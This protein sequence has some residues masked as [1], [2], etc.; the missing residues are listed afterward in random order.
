MKGRPSNIPASASARLLKLAKER[1][2]DYQLVLLRYANE[3]LLYHLAVS[4]HVDRFVLKGAA[5]FTVWTGQPHR[6][7]RDLDLL[8]FGSPGEQDL[9][10]VFVEVL[11]SSDVDDGLVFETN[12]LTVGPIREDQDYGGVRILVVARLGSAKIPIQVD[13]GFGDAITPAATEITF[14]TLLDFPAPRLRAYPRETVLAEKVEAMVKLGVANSRM[15]DFYDL[16]ILAR[17]F[18][19]DGVLV[20]KAVEATFARRGTEL[21]S[22]TP[23]ALTA[24]FHDD[25][26]KRAQWGAFRR[27]SATDGGELADAIEAVAAFVQPILSAVAGGG[28]LNRSWPR[29]GP[30]T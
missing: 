23:V 12:A 26:S 7:T 13:I 29:G 28:P 30:W 16:M 6:A 9:R 20:S 15:K 27:K 10:A 14:P 2:D 5:L 17:M 4:K 24:T 3:R 25:P 19:F 11:S 8:G 22:G 1:G 18:E 21:P